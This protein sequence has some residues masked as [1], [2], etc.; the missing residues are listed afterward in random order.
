MN[1]RQLRYFVAIV[2]TGSFTAGA[3]RAGIS[4]PGMSQQIRALEAS[5]GGPL[6]V[7]GSRRLQLTPAGELL[8]AKAKS[9]VAFADEIEGEARTVLSEGPLH[10]FLYSAATYGYARIAHALATYG[11]TRDRGVVQ[12]VE[13]KSQAELQQI[14]QNTPGAIGVGAPPEEGRFAFVRRLPD[15][16]F[17]VVGPDLPRSGVIG[18]G[19]LARICGEHWI[20]VRFRNVSSGALRQLASRAGFMPRVAHHVGRV[21]NAIR[22]AL[23]GVGYALVPEGAVATGTPFARFETPLVRPVA[24]FANERSELLEAF[25]ASPRTRRLAPAHEVL[26]PAV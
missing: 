24:V 9:L 4:Q 11:A 7:P 18:A 21:E 12:W 19:E 14:V 13:D 1:I 16:E 8:F 3:R 2:E 26:A 23:A 17:V 15:E 25:V 22:L 20:E 10:G 6:T 5:L